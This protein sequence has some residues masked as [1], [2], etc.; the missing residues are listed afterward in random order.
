[1]Y[2]KCN[3]SNA[4]KN[5]YMKLIC[6]K[7]LCAFYMNSDFFTRV[8]SHDHDQ[9]HASCSIF[10]VSWSVLSTHSFYRLHMETLVFS[11]ASVII[12]FLSI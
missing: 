12:S 1:M 2:T 3:L 7:N 11:S 9:L 8:S 5:L 6:N 10:D 4:M